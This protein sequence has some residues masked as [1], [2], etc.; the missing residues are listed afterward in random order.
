MAYDVELADRVRDLVGHERGLEEKRMFGGLAFLVD[1]HLAVSASSK[2]GL[3]VRVKPASTEELAAQPGVA[4]FE[5]RGRAMD[6]WLHVAAEAV[7]GDADL[8]RWVRRA[9]DHA[10]ALPTA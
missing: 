3:L 1:G 5:M 8:E 7:A 9:V 6:G 2:G 4:R 10:R